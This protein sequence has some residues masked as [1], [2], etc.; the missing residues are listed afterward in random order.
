MFVWLKMHKNVV[1]SLKFALCSCYLRVLKITYAA[2]FRTQ[3]QALSL[4]TEC[5]KSGILDKHCFCNVFK[6]L[7]NVTKSIKAYSLEVCSIT[8]NLE[9]IFIPVWGIQRLL[10]FHCKSQGKEEVLARK[11]YLTD[12]KSTDFLEKLPSLQ[13]E[14]EARWKLLVYGLFE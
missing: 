4:S 14:F 8:S 6:N 7:S 1:S 3:M 13:P 5:R 9:R 12:K 11:L 10:K 2:F